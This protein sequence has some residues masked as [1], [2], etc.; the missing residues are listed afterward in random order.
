MVALISFTHPGRHA[1]S[2]WIIPADPLSGAAEKVLN[3]RGPDALLYTIGWNDDG[4]P[5][6]G[7]CLGQTNTP[8]ATA[9][10]FVTALA[11]EI[12][13]RADHYPAWM[14]PWDAVDVG[15]HPSDPTEHIMRVSY[16]YPTGGS[17]V[18]ADPMIVSSSGFAVGKAPY[19]VMTF[20]GKDPISYAPGI[21]GFQPFLFTTTGNPLEYPMAVEYEMIT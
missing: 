14:W 7:Q 1:Y 21:L 18:P 8:A 9:A 3:I 17:R 11:G 16:R 13:Y 2:D 10:E 4:E 19:G 15:P 5:K 6:P 20:R 12:H